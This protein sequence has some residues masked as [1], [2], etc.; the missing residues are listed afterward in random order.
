MGI[1]NVVCAR[2]VRR[3]GEVDNVLDDGGHGV[4]G[5]PVGTGDVVGKVAE[6]MGR[7]DQGG[8]P[9]VSI[10]DIGCGNGPRDLAYAENTYS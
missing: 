5:D 7:F 2:F 10:P 9:F 3:R 1:Q 4:H 8:E 6:K